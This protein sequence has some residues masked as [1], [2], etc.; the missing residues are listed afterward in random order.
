[1]DKLMEF[2]QFQL[3]CLNLLT[4]LNSENKSGTTNSL[5]D[6]FEFVR[7]ID[8]QGAQGRV[9]IL[10]Y[11]KTGQLV[12]YKAPR[13]I[14]YAIRHENNIFEVIRGIR[15]WCPNFCE[16]IGI[17]KTK[18]SFHDD[19]KISPFDKNSPSL[20][21]DLMIAEYI[22]DSK[23][24]SERI[25]EL[26]TGR[27]MSV[28]R[29]I[30]TA[31]EIGYRKF[32]F[33]H[34]DLHTDN[35]LLVSCPKNA[36]FLYHLGDRQVCIPTHGVVPLM[37]D[38]GFSF[39]KQQQLNLYM[40]MDFTNSGYLSCVA[41]PYYDARIFLINMLSHMTEKDPKKY[42][43]LDYDIKK[44]YDGLSYNDRTGWDDYG[45]YSASD[46]VG[47]TIIDIETKHNISKLI[48][49]KPYQ[50][51]QMFQSLIKVPLKN[52]KNGNFIPFYL[53]FA[54]EF[55]KFEKTART[56][57]SKL[58]ILYIIVD[59]ARKHHDLYLSDK[60]KGLR[61]FR[62][63]FSDQ[64][65][66]T[67]DFYNP[68]EDADYEA[69]LSNLFEMVNC[70]ETVYYRVLEKAIQEKKELY[71]KID[72]KTNMQIHDLIERKHTTEYELTPDTPVYVWN[73]ITETNMIVS[74]F[75]SENC[76]EFNQLGVL[77]RAKWLWTHINERTD[78]LV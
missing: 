44:I 36:I 34:Y 27:L 58:Y 41:D 71:S 22:P 74:K 18:L 14:D 60:E 61:E 52:R 62:K 72:L 57:F 76:K 6:H 31:I 26:S 9:G 63:E 51:I 1:M 19:T 16:G 2:P 13:H 21:T 77:E 49:D 65:S 8:Y 10:K 48:P 20:Y 28:I 23:G 39:V 70:I 54:T 47:Y 29:Q 38:Y 11:K 17:A 12:I 68:P 42:A 30:L 3:E 56:T 40:S 43:G 64:I 5:L 46:M 73:M 35:I 7:Q 55:A 32:G 67:F 15:K 24:L 59:A 45:T 75:S 4:L 53:N 66:L 37:I 33:V 69:L 25:E 50:C 78:I